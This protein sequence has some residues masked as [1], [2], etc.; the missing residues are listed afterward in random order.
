MESRVAGKGGVT[1]VRNG[2]ADGRRPTLEGF[3]DGDHS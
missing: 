2:L 1:M 3:A